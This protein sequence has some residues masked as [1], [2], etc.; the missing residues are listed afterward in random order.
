MLGIDKAR[1]EYIIS[2]IP[3]S[4]KS[5]QIVT[6][7]NNKR[8]DIFEPK[9]VLK[10]IQRRINKEIFEKVLYPDY[11]HGGLAERDYISNAS[12]H[13]NK[14][15]IICLDIT[16]FYPSISKQHVYSIFKNL[17][18]F[19]PEVSEALTSLVTINGQVPQ[20]SCCSSYIAN[21]IFF[22][23][24]YNIVND[25]RAKGVDYTRLLDDIT[26][27]SSK[28]LNDLQ[29]SQIIK[30]ITGMISRY[31]LKINEKKT[32]I[33]HTS[34]SS[35]KL[36]VTGLWVKHG[37]PKLTKKDRRYIRYLVYLCEKQAEYDRESPEYHSL[38]NKSSGKVAQMARLRH[39]QSIDLREKLN[40][41]LPVYD[42]YKINKLKRMALHYEHSFTAHL[43]NSQIQKINKLKYEFDIVGRTDK[44]TAKIYKRKLA[45]I[46]FSSE[47][48][49]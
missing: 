40:G 6:G 12:T 8:R 49:K 16:N 30:K 28:D 29:K 17:M 15:T 44:N 36:C 22:N 4:Y 26:V 11:L 47:K 46:L 42:E 19:S 21:L 1:L 39:S 5:F 18:R 37:I 3:T 20:G 41:I 31:R 43:E 14:K 48:V 24:E 13:T 9:R 34:N 33:E 7:R 23:Y 10:A 25:L 27:S 32:T 45:S 35:A 38:W 2:S